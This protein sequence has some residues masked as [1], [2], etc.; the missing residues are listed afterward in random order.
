MKKHKPGASGY[1][2]VWWCQGS[3][4]WACRIK[5]DGKTIHIGLYDDP[6]EAAKIYDETIIKEKGFSKDLCLN[7]PNGKVHKPFS[8]MTNEELFG[9][10]KPNRT[11]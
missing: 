7:F 5:R 6:I 1:Y 9:G 4:K 11:L 3:R 8:E 2:G 10:K